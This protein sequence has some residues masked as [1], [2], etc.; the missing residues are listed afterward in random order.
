[1]SMTYDSVTYI[2][3]KNVTTRNRTL[4]LFSKKLSLFVS[5]SSYI[6]NSVCSR[7]PPKSSA[8]AAFSVYMYTKSPCPSN[9]FESSVFSVIKKCVCGSTALCGSVNPL[10]SGSTSSRTPWTPFS[11]YFA[12]TLSWKYI[13]D[14]G[15]YGNV[16]EY[17]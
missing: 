5:A 13:V 1:M 2:F 8:I 11:A 7:K 6:L 4:T 15:I 3:I 10:H 14:G 9:S 12:N 17:N 16:D